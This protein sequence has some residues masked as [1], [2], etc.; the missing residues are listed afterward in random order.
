MFSWFKKKPSR[1]ARTIADATQV[2]AHFALGNHYAD[3]SE[4]DQAI[5][6]YR[7]AIALDG[8][9]FK[10]HFNLGNTLYFRGKLD[11]AAECYRRAITLKPEF[12]DAHVALGNALTDQKRFEEAADAFRGALAG[13]PD[14]AQAHSNLGMALIGLQRY[15]EAIASFDTAIGLMPEHAEAHNNRGIALGKLNRLTEA[16]ASYELA[17]AWQ[18]DNADAHFNHANALI[19]LGRHRDALAGFARATQIKP[20][21]A[22]AYF[23]ESTCHLTVGDYAAGLPKY[24]SRWRL[25]TGRPDFTQPIWLGAH[26]LQGKTIFVYAEQGLGDTLQFCRYVSALAARG[27]RVMF[28]V[29]P[30]LQSLLARLNGVE[31]VSARGDGPP[32]HFD[33]H[34]P[35]LSLP[36]A[37]GTTVETIPCEVPYL[38]ALPH[39]IAGSSRILG[40]KKGMRIGLCWKG[41]ARYLRDAERSP[42]I[43]PF[44][45][46][47]RCAGAMFYPL[48]PGGHDA[49]QQ[50]GDGATGQPLA[51]NASFEDT[52]AL[53]MNLDLVISCDTSVAHLAGA[54]GKP[55]WLVLPAQ[56]DWRWLLHR[57]DSPWYPTARLFRQQI[58]G[59]WPEVFER[60]AARLENVIAG[61]TPTVWPIETR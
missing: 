31:A 57:E 43:E 53:I 4:W 55:V 49:F 54:L 59:D 20:D 32:A 1:P 16:L 33:F 25:G 38:A 21:F 45:K 17:L 56:A 6:H 27:A 10:A 37:F 41:G 26:S 24:E 50:A 15:E 22:E 18:P 19:T 51:E 9:F 60:V 58:A 42:G 40:V 61:Q 5:E 46:L 36:L 2:E 8:A 23:S 39:A 28:E 12:A 13:Q 30:E 48:V 14:F 44:K 29:Q 35:L 7:A 3:R 34:S 47:F 52:A 11:E